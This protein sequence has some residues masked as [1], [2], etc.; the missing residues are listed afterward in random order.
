M[1]SAWRQG[2]TKSYADLQPAD[3]GSFEIYA[4]FG[5]VIMAAV[6]IA[7]AAIAWAPAIAAW[8]RAL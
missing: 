1:G 8:W 6:A 3:E 2:P 5:C 4:A 7:A